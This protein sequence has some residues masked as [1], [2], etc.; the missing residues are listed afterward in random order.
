MNGDDGVAGKIEVAQ[1]D[2]PVWDWE[3]EDI[4]DMWIMEMESPPQVTQ[5]QAYAQALRS[6]GSRNL[7]LLFSCPAREEDRAGPTSAAAPPGQPA[8]A[9]SHHARKKKRA[10]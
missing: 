3:E 6:P 1:P 5:R 10:T 2:H 9:S 4:L 7:S 8:Q